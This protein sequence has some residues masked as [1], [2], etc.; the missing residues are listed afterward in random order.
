MWDLG[1]TGKKLGFGD[2][3]PFEFGITEIKFKFES[4]WFHGES[5]WDYTRIWNWDYGITS[6]FEIG[7]SGLQD[8]FLTRPY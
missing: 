1:I 5:I 2:Y 7:I 4:T 6:L 3:T 8:P